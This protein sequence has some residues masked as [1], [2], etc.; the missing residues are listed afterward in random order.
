M[1]LRT[2]VALVMGALLA[3]AA[4]AIMAAPLNDKTIDDKSDPISGEW[5]ASF[6]AMGTTTP[7][8]FE[9]KLDGHKVTGKAESAHTGPGTLSNGT[10]T[11]NRLTFTMDFAAHEAIIVTGTLKDGKLVG[12]FRTEGRQEKWEAMKRGEGTT[13][14]AAAATSGA[15]VSADPIS[16]EWDATLEATGTKAPVTFKFKLDGDR[17]TGT[18][19]SEHLGAGTLTNGTWAD[20]LISFTIESGP[21]KLALTGQL[22]DGKLVGEFKAGQGMQ[23]TWVA[24]K[25]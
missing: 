12:E 14:S 6:Y 8:T 7:F 4:S 25:R 3:S 16:G 2:V 11:D 15:H 18:S 21:M 23:G 22:K 5:D 13:K 1:R 20:N 17:V 19:E 24:A 10:W 9:L